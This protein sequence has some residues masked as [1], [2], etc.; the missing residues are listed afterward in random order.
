MWYKMTTGYENAKIRARSL[1][2]TDACLKYIRNEHITIMTEHFVCSC[3]TLLDQRRYTFP[4]EPPLP[5][6]LYPPFP[7]PPLHN[8]VSS[9]CPFRSLLHTYSNLSPTQTA[10]PPP[11][12]SFPKKQNRHSQKNA[13]KNTP[14]KMVAGGGKSS[15]PGCVRFFGLKCEE[16]RKGFCERFLINFSPLQLLPPLLSTPKAG[17]PPLFGPTP[18]L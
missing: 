18:F 6:T 16:G 3:M 1:L 8:H 11:G 9:I 17:P 13:V 2:G 12:P 7:P 10:P 4:I 5:R 15:V 14:P